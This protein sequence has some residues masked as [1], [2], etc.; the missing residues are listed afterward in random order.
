MAEIK[1]ILSG[2]TLSI[3]HHVIP[4][5]TLARTSG[6]IEDCQIFGGYIER[7][8]HSIGTQYQLGKSGKALSSA[9]ALKKAAGGGK[10]D[11]DEWEEF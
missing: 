6:R 11:K 2:K 9:P 3:E 7:V 1:D 4:L 5:N 10:Y 8:D